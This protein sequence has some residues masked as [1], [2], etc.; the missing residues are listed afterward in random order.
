[1]KVRNNRTSSATPP[2]APPSTATATTEEE[3][4]RHSHRPQPAGQPG[5]GALGSRYL[6]TEA[7]AVP[8]CEDIRIASGVEGLGG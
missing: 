7:S 5:T 6:P 2:A 3:E 8:Q 1:V 4:T